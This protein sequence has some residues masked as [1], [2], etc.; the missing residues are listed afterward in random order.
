MTIAPTAV[1]PTAP[2]AAD[3]RRWLALAVVMTAAFMDLVDVT[4]VNIAVPSIQRDTGA[5]FSAVQ[6]ITGGYA[7]A[8][9]LGLITGGRLG[10]IF[11]RKRLFLLGI[12]GF[13]VAS[14]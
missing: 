9:A 2:A 8:F 1:V 14:S 13:T 7:L 10:D 3:S 5:S 12:G 11:G 4:I 6:W